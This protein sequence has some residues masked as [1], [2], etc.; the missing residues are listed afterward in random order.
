ML[1]CCTCKHASSV[2]VGDVSLVSKT[3]GP[4]V[5]RS[6]GTGT[7]IF[8]EFYI[9]L[10]KSIEAAAIDEAIPSSHSRYTFCD[11]CFDWPQ[12]GQDRQEPYHNSCGGSWPALTCAKLTSPVTDVYNR[13]S[14]LGAALWRVCDNPSGWFQPRWA[15][16]LIEARSLN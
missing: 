12:V 4:S 13:L 16:P 2:A 15:A 8:K 7:R 11:V 14:V 3:A 5:H 10:I 6:L 1:I 9:A